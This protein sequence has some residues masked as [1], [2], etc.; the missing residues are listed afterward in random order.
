MVRPTG[1]ACTQVKVFYPSGK[2][3]AGDCESGENRLHCFELD[4]WVHAHLRGFDMHQFGAVWY[5]L[6]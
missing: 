1:G 6:A 3:A 5:R 4:R 2:G